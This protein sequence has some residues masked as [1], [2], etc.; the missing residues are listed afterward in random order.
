MYKYNRKNKDLGNWKDFVKQE[1]SK[2]IRNVRKKQFSKTSNILSNENV[3]TFL[4]N[5]QKQFV[6]VSIGK[7]ANNFFCL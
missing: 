1:V 2:G 5:F 6:S 4:N 3:K 7:A